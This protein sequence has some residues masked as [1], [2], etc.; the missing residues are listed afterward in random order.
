MK[1]S[2]AILLVLFLATA[3]QSSF[4]ANDS[5]LALGNLNRVAS[6]IDHLRSLIPNKI[7]RECNSELDRLDSNIARLD[8][9]LA[10]LSDMTSEF[11]S[12]CTQLSSTPNLRQLFLKMHTITIMM[13][14]RVDSEFLR[15]T[16]ASTA[17]NKNKANDTTSNTIVDQS[18]KN[19]VYSISFNLA[20]QFWVE[21]DCPPVPLDLEV[22]LQALFYNLVDFIQGKLGLSGL[23][24]S[25][26]EAVHDGAIAGITKAVLE[27]QSTGKCGVY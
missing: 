12:L 27:V 21:L 18:L 20:Y 1:K 16:K 13:R 24:S 2:V 22:L 4:A 7:A 8:S 11:R 17:S 15:L 25:I 14:S 6:N 10:S 9:N 19:Q 5:R 3:V 23:D 26:E